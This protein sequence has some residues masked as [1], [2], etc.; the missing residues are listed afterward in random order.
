VGFV[1]SDFREHPVA[2]L[3]VECWERIDRERIETFAYSLA[4]A[5]QTALGQRAG[6]AFDHF[7]DCWA[8]SVEAIAR[9]IRAD[10]IDVLIDLNG[11]TTS[12]RSEVFALRPAPVQASW[13]GYLG[14]MGAPWYDYIITDRF[15]C[16][17]EAQ[18]FFSERFLYLPDCYCPSD[19]KR[20]VAAR[21]PSRAE[22]ALPEA[23]LVLACFNHSYKILPQLFDVWMRLLTALPGS[24]LWLAPGS[25]TARAN[26]A[27]EAQ[28]RGVDP[29]RLI[30]APRLDLPEHLA[31]HAH[32]D[33][34]LDT[35]PY[36]AGT[37]AN[38]AL[39]MGVPVVTYAGATMASRVAGSQLTAIGL[40]ELITHSLA[41]YEAL[42]LALGREPARM[43][44]LKA[45][46]SA[47]RHT[48]PLFDM[49]RF[50]RAFDDL[51]IEAWENRA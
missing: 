36:N 15:V 1:S 28:A 9:R 39:F 46:L 18:G 32:V 2:R 35:T 47:N 30:F 19:S 5:D 48:T 33:L 34:Y 40:P 50:T 6:R 4:P 49:A 45:R 41:D 27:S 25:A 42:V 37:T 22:C 38:D 21:V 14:T 26:L 43:A 10:G 12:E 17:L 20:A 11:Y 13:L 8:E 16:P 44:Q 31:R 51:L 24:V 3:A 7:V 23:G 29:A